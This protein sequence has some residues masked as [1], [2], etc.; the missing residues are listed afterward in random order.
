MA[1]DKSK[2]GPEPRRALGRGLDALLP[3]VTE[4]AASKAEQEFQHVPVERLVPSPSQPRKRFDDDGLRE[5]A[6]S[7]KAQGMIQPI[8]VRK[9][10]D[11]LEII[12]GERRWRAAQR[13]GLREVPV[14]IKDVAESTA[15]EWAL[16]E[17]IQRRDLDPMETAEAY[18]RLLDEHR[19]DHGTL[20]QR[21]GKSRVSITNS[22][23]LLLLPSAVRERVVAGELSEGHA[24]VLLGVA[25]DPGLMAALA[26]EIVAKRLSVRETEARVRKAAAPATPSKTK[27]AEPETP[28]KSS[29][30]SPNVRELEARLSAS[31]GAP[32]VVREDP[33]KQSGTVEIAYDSLD[34]LDRF[35]EKVLGR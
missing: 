32:V 26:S 6:E 5:L 20:A 16:V 11:D 33:S 21:L 3:S 25:E 12:A 28:R 1:N 23:R 22:L 27:S 17:N 2:K 29:T 31:I 8:V 24:K 9:L 15:F 7:L 19:Y 18:K 10:G 13:A 35:I 34:Q 30:E 14:V 4:R